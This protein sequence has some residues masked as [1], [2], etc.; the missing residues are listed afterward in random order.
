MGQGEL[1][2]PAGL[3][4]DP[5]FA[6]TRWSV[7]VA[8]GANTCA[9]SREALAT[10]SR[11]YWY[12]LYSFV[13]R[14]GAD[15]PEAADLTQ[16]FFARLLEQKIVRGADPHRGRF[17]SY[18]LGALKHYLSHEAARAGALKRGGG[19]E[20][21]PLDLSDAEARYRL[22]PAHDLTP[23]KVFERHWAVTVLELAMKDLERQAAGAGKHKQFLR[24]KEFLAGGGADSYQ[25]AAA[26]LGM[27]E[28]AV[29]VAAHRLR[30]RYG[31]LVRE[32]IR[33]TVNSSAQIDE[34][35]RDLF[36]AMGS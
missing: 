35:V 17:R 4:T 9:E 28:G 14:R 32:Q 25:A 22:E 5:R 7:V 12:P 26:D 10:L 18:L 31:E 23:E 27:E 34:E 15:P 11:L 30:R 8:A 33:Q 6:T 2:Q 19:R 21:I 29:R 3:A 13:R 24:L 20:I 36:A 16:G 1:G